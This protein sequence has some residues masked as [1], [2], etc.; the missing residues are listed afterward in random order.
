MLYAADFVSEGLHGIS[1]AAHQT[2]GILI[3]V[4]ER[5]IYHNYFTS[6]AKEGNVEITVLGHGCAHR[7]TDTVVNDDTAA[8]QIAPDGYASFSFVKI[9]L[10]KP[11]QVG[12]R[13]T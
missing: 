13:E 9:F 6:E 4:V 3:I 7:K 12:W 10:S 1:Q 11:F 8:I 5:V 2:V